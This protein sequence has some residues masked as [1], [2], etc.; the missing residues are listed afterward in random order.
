M[1]VSWY[2]KE[3]DADAVSEISRHF[4]ISPVLSEIIYS[5]G[6][7]T[8]AE[9]EQFLNPRISDLHSPFLMSGMEE[10]VAIIKRA[11]QSKVKIGI[12]SDSD[13]D[14]IT[15]LT[16]LLKL[17]RKSGS[18][19]MVRYPTGAENYGLTREIID[20]FHN[21]GAGLIITADSGIRDIGEISHARG[22]GIE[23]IVT[24]H[25]EQDD[26]LPDACIV[27]PKINDCRYPNKNLAG[28]GVVFKLSTALL[29]S[30]LPVYNKNIYIVSE[31]SCGISFAHVRNG[32]VLE[33]E[34]NLSFEHFHGRTISAGGFCLYDGPPGKADRYVTGEGL[35]V[36]DYLSFI[37]KIDRAASGVTSIEGL[38]DYYRAAQSHG[39]NRLE[40]L[41]RVFLELQLYGSQKISDFIS[42]SI[43]L[44]SIG[45]IADIMPLSGENRALVK[46]G[47]AVLNRN[48]H[49]GISRIVRDREIDSKTISW[50]IAPFLN[51]PGRFGRTELAVGFLNES[52][53]EALTGIINEITSLNN[54]RKDLLQELVEQFSSGIESYNRSPGD[55]LVYIRSAEV[56]DGIAGLVANKISEKTGRPAIVVSDREGE[57]V[58]KGSGRCILEFNFLSFMEKYSHR[59]ERLGGHQQAFGFSV[60]SSIVDGI[61]ESLDR[62]LLDAAIPPRKYIVD[63]EVDIADIDLGLALELK[64]LEPFGKCNEEPLFLSKNVK[65][66]AFS[67][68]GGAGA[69]GK[70]L[71]RGK[72]DIEAIGWKMADTMEALFR[73]DTLIDMLYTI[74]VNEFRGMESPRLI[75][76]GIISDGS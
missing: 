30:Y 35:S 53:G 20:D 3:I 70:F 36:Y 2:K 71:F 52:S 25:H 60:Q 43:G 23:V 41:V 21:G 59:F 28:V 47:I 51:T 4:D 48:R 66:G 74:E 46:T 54:H 34:L 61:M 16:I 18:E 9:V 26:V 24:D 10:A 11:I 17:L 67:R 1:S 65:P 44:V 68:F 76:S 29:F 50:T 31:S 8:L 7:N 27:N 22:L 63:A 19:I 37:K 14:G 55:R 62:D 32:I 39:E 56:P 42:G 12:F 13:I 45:S 72:A 38:F 49:E 58:V 64:K 75:I 40:G 15:S 33:K 5:R 6:Y 57:T 73:A 69:H